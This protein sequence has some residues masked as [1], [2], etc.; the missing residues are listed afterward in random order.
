MGPHSGAPQCPTLPMPPAP[1]D[2]PSTPSLSQGPWMSWM[3]TTNL[4]PRRTSNDQHTR[5]GTPPPQWSRARCSPSAT[6]A[7]PNR[8]TGSSAFGGF[9]TGLSTRVGTRCP[10]L[11]HVYTATIGPAQGC[12]QRP[13]GHDTHAVDTCSASHW[14]S[15][16]QHST[17]CLGAP[18][19]VRS[20]A[21][22]I[23]VL[24]PK[25]FGC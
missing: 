11:S 19:R 3:C 10:A 25:R 17:A 13:C 16:A 21:M 24:A 4:N 7:C 1:H 20:T 9:G 12:S 15:P 8:Q 22:H 5:L 6:M 14:N 23:A 18:G 2:Q